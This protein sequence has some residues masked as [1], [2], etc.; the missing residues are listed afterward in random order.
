MS[1]GKAGPLLCVR[2]DCQSGEKHLKTPGPAVWYPVV[3]VFAKGFRYAPPM[4]M[5]MSMALCE[6][7]SRVIQIDDLLT[8]EGWTR[9]CAVLKATGKAE[10]DRERTQLNWW[11]IADAQAGRYPG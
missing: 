2:T 7:C 8:H 10:P 3:R 6:M 1:F 5:L 11:P 4:Q 9:I